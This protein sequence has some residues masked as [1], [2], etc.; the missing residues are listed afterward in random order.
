MGGA[1]G[2]STPFNE[3]KKRKLWRREQMNC[4]DVKGDMGFSS[5]YPGSFLLLT[6]GRLLSMG[7]V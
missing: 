5:A 3:E 6:F 7:S 1:G 4:L 2:W